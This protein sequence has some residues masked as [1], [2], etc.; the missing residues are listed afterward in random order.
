MKDDGY[1]D[2]FD[3]IL[4]ASFP[5]KIVF[6]IPDNLDKFIPENQIAFYE[7][8][9]EEVEDDDIAGLELDDET[10]KIYEKSIHLLLHP[11]GKPHF[12]FLHVL[13]LIYEEWSSWN[14]RRT[15]F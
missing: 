5:M 8:K 1:A 4:G 6:E 15:F 10:H 12:N 11:S 7:E 2:I 14:D 9:M 13:K 3:T